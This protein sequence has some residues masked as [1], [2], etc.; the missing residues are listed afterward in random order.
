MNE[1]VEQFLLESREL[2]EQAIDDLLALEEKPGDRERLDS[3]FRAFHTLKGAAGIV[4]FAA[5]ARTLHAA[6][7]IL[8]AIRSS[9]GSIAPSV[10]TECLTCLDLTSRWLDAMQENGETPATAEADADDMIARLVASLDSDGRDQGPLPG[11]D[12]WLERLRA[13]ASENFDGPRTALRYVPD[14]DAFFRGQDPIAIIAAL[15]NL[16]KLDFALTDPAVSL[17]TM[18]TFGCGLDIVALIGARADDVRAALTACP[19][20]DGNSRTELA[21]HGSGGR[22]PVEGHFV[23][24]SAAAGLAGRWT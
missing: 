3:A 17:E 11:N 15:P 19:G 24:G 1:F 16:L 22:F 18:N 6:E 8:A 5:M 2:V 13:A 4:D 20:H 23:A 9:D 12:G 21:E 10:L 7:E 14:Q